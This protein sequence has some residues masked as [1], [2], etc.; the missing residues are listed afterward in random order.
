[1]MQ[2]DLSTGDLCAPLVTTFIPAD[3]SDVGQ[4]TLLAEAFHHCLCHC[5]SMGWMTYKD[6]I[7]E[8]SKAEA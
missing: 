7:W 6:G 8:P 2:T 3:Y 4:G 1:M 5:D